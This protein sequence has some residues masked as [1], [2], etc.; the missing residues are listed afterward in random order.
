MYYITYRNQGKRERT[1]P[2]KNY[3][4]DAIGDAQK[5][6]AKEQEQAIDVV[7]EFMEVYCQ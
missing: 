6:E 3:E 1:P 2:Y 4:R 7:S 5:R